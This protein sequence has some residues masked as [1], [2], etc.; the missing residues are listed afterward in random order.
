MKKSLLFLA[1]LL[2]AAM[3]A[4]AQELLPLFGDIDRTVSESN[5]NRQ[6][7][8]LLSLPFFDD[9]AESDTRHNTDKWM[10]NGGTHVN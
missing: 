1:F 3:G 7:Q 10:P 9:F 2:S 5:N 8:Q 6:S 4:K